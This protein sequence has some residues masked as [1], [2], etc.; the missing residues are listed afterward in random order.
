ME[1]LSLHLLAM[2]RN[3]LGEPDPT[4]ITEGATPSLRNKYEMEELFD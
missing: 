3:P 1:T 2:A 4:C